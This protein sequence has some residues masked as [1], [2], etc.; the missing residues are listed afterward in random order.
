MYRI[1][2]DSISLSFHI[3]DIIF[4]ETNSDVI[5]KSPN[6]KTYIAYRYIFIKKKWKGIYVTSK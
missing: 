3:I 5:D 4:K 2:S 6:K 1:L